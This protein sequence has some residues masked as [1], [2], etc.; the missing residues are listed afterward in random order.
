MYIAK[1]FIYYLLWITRGDNLQ[2]KIAGFFSYIDV[3][4]LS[5]LD[6]MFR[7]YKTRRGNSLIDRRLRTTSWK[8]A[9]EWIL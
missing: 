6:N 5:Y 9:A 1:F 3:S 2:I 7:I 4:N 8:G